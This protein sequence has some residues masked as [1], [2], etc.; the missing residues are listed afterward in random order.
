M[1]I[2]GRWVITIFIFIFFVNSILTLIDSK[3]YC[4][5]IVRC[6]SC[7]R[8]MRWWLCTHSVMCCS[9]CCLYN[10]STVFPLSASV[11]TRLLSFILFL[12]SKNILFLFYFQTV[13]LFFSSVTWSSLTTCFTYSYCC[14]HVANGCLCPTAN[15][16]IHD[17]CLKC[18]M[19]CKHLPS[20]WFSFC[21]K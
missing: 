17:L 12:A 21:V 4:S 18:R 8:G 6:W 9:Q 16:P 2:W 20:N 3:F 5:L 7:C 19:Y 13:V 10:V 14:I 11:L 15:V 1:Y